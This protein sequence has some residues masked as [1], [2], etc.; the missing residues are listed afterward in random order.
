M[1]GPWDLSDDRTFLVFAA[2]V[3]AIVVVAV[4]LFGRSDTGRVLRA[5]RGSEV[6]SQSI[7][8]SPARGR[9]IAFA[10]SGFVA[11]FGGAMVAMHQQAVGYDRNF[12]PLIA[13]FWLVL[14][15]TFG[16]HRPMAAVLAATAFSLF[17]RVILQG[18]FLGWILRSPD[19]IPEPFPIA[20]SWMMILFG[21][22]VITYAKHPEGV[23]DMTRAQNAE[24]RRKRAAKRSA[25]ADRTD[26]ASPSTPVRDEVEEP[27]G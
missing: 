4:T 18:N 3:L 23:I 8:I 26:E 10:A 15:V 9:V 16:V 6:A 25:K 22:G 5:L 1:V 14:V 19:R 7:G 11:A 20:P 21:L 27:V 2:I 12:A 24:K 13:M 17:D